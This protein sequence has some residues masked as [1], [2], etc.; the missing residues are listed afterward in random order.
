MV[1]Y[2]LP[3]TR[4]TLSVSVCRSVAEASDGGHHGVI[5]VGLVDLLDRD[6]RHPALRLGLLGLVTGMGCFGGLTPTG[7]LRRSSNSIT[8]HGRRR[9]A[10][11]VRRLRQADGCASCVFLRDRAHHSVGYGMGGDEA[12]GGLF[13][14]LARLLARSVRLRDLDGP[15]TWAEARAGRK[16]FPTPLTRRECVTRLL[17]PQAPPL[18][19]QHPAP[20]RCRRTLRRE[21]HDRRQVR[22]VRPD[23][24]FQ[25]V[26]PS[27]I[28]D[29]CRFAGHPAWSARR[30]HR[31]AR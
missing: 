23:Q 3:S 25:H 13:D 14:Q 7:R 15:A 18:L 19:D 2:H 30:R 27:G 6:R 12:I 28:V 31:R 9:S 10:P 22:P 5:G 20:V 8:D 21:V 17:F 4:R 1:M 11:E 16:P 26:A 29:E 24:R